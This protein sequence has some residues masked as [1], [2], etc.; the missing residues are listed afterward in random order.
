MRELIREC[1]QTKED[2]KETLKCLV[3][4]PLL[5]IGS[6]VFVIALGEVMGK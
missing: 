4:I 5:L 6:Y 2:V 3:V 1:F